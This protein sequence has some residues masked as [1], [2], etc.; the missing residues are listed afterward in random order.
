MGLS[1]AC[2]GA[3]IQGVPPLKKAEYGLILT[4]SPL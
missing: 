4:E 2:G 3:S 1:M